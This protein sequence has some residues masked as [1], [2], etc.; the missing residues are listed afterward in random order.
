MESTSEPS[1][2][3]SAA[4][5]HLERGFR[6]EQAGT[7]ERA[8]EAYRDALAARPTE[9][10][11]A[12]ARLRVA[13]VYRSMARWAEARVE[14]REAVRIARAIG[15]NDLAAEALNIEVGALQ[16][17]GF[18][19]D[20]DV[21]AL[22]ALA[23]AQSHRVRGITLQ[24]LGR[25]AAERR[26]FEKSDEYFDASISA[27]R[28]ANYEVGLAIALANAAKAA[29]DRGD[30]ERSIEIGMESVG[31]A[32]RLN[33][34]DVLLTAVQNQA[35]AHVAIGDLEAAESL[36]TEALGHFTTAR[37]PVRQAECLEIMG[38]IS[39]V[40]EDFATAARC[41]ARARDLATAANDLPL[42]ERLARKAAAA[43]EHREQ[44]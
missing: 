14:S 31:I 33:A 43:D 17:Q 8:L 34:L 32:R 20:A 24:N 12:E 39:E 36:L 41:Y 9:P 5:A 21:I 19:D 29:L 18:F 4:R 26:E 15:T 10:E 1:R 2:T 6:F 3:I 27:F 23:L 7:L 11:E 40:R 38:R 28:S 13:R 25:S 16:L 37:N 30:A 44:A 22:E 42:V 35:A